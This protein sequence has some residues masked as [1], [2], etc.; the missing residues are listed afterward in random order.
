[1]YYS[2]LSLTLLAGLGWGINWDTILK[3]KSK[4][5][6]HMQLKTEPNNTIN[7]I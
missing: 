2:A 1:M 5:P 7:S 6:D 4:N 3:K